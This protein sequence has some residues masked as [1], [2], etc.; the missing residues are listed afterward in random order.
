MATGI[1][2]A[3]REHSE[4]MADATQAVTQTMDLQQQVARLQA[5]LEISRQVHSTTREEEVLE[6]VLR[7]VV[8]ELEMAGAAFSNS[9]L[10]YGDA[11]AKDADGHFSGVYTYALDDREGKRMTELIVAPPD[12]RAITLYEADFLEGLVLQAAVALE[13]ARNHER[14]LQWAR[15]QQDLDAARQI[16][17]SLLPQE[18]PHV[19]GFSIAVRSQTCYE[20]GG[21]YA[22]IIH[23]PDGSLLLAVA[24]VAGK[25][26]ASAIMATSFRAAFRAMAVTGIPLDQLATRMNQHHWQ[27]GEEARRRYVTAIFLKLDTERGEVEIVNAGH[28]PGFVVDPDGTQ[29]QIEAAGTPL[30]LL[31]GMS[32]SSEVL[33]FGRG[34]RLLFYTDGLTEV[35]LEDEE[36]GQDRLLQ[37]FSNTPTGKADGILEALWVAIHGFSG[38]GP[39][40]DDMTALVLC[41]L[42]GA[43]SLPENQ[44]DPRIEVSTESDCT[45]VQV[46][47]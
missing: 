4:M 20:V 10:S 30:G 32:Y 26:L 1:P 22:D 27:E 19:P 42:A 13:N 21:D 45:S 9:E 23:L 12:G 2:P 43:E 39:Q 38:G 33:C 36:F 44:P 29:H 46:S 24:D 31:P 35:F 3:T 40:E 47:A 7:I 16:Q 17:R 15:V 11:P 37:E 8:R 28:N 14:N 25:G 41:H 5:L 6:S 18:M 34:S